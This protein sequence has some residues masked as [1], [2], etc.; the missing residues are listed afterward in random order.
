MAKQVSLD[1]GGGVPLSLGR[2]GKLIP[3]E[4]NVAT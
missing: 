1:V 2:A 3:W 4:V